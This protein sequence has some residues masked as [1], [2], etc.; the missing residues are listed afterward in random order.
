MDSAIFRVP[1]LRAVFFISLVALAIPPAFNIL[2]SYPSFNQVLVGFTEEDS[3]E[4]ANHFARTLPEGAIQPGDPYFQRRAFTQAVDAIVTD[5]DIRKLRIFSPSGEIVYSTVESE[6]GKINEKPY[7]HGIVAKGTPFSKVVVKGQKSAEGVTS[8][9]HVAEVYIPVMDEG[10]FLGALEFYHDL[11][12]RREALEA[13][14]RY[15]AIMSLAISVFLFFTIFFTL[16]RGAKAH[17]NQELQARKIDDLGRLRESILEAIGDGI[18]GVDHKGRSLFL[19][20]AGERL[21]GWKAEDFIGQDQHNLSHHTRSDGSSYPADECPIHLCM[22]DGGTRHIEGEVFWN[23]SGHSFPVDYTVAPLMETGGKRGAVVA[24]RD[25]S[26]RRIMEEELLLAKETAEKAN[27]TK[28]EFLANMS[29]EIRTP[30]N[31]VIGLSR[32]CLETGLDP[33][34]KDYV[35]KIHFS[36][37][38]LLGIINDILDFSKIEAGKLAVEHV[39]FDLVRILQNLTNLIAH[40]ADEKGVAFKI[41]CT[42]EVPGGFL[43]DPLRIEQVLRNLADNAVK[44]SDKGGEVSVS[45]SLEER[46]DER[47]TLLFKVRDRGIGLSEEAI[48][49]LFQSFSQADGS[50]TRKFGGTGLG[51]AICKQLVE[52]MGGRIWVES[53]EGE[54]S[55]FFFTTDL[56]IETYQEQVE[57]QVYAG[58]RGRRVLI[59]DPHEESRSVIDDMVRGFGFDVVRAIDA[60]SAVRLVEGGIEEG[61]PFD[62]VLIDWDVPGSTGASGWSM[63]RSRLTARQMP[64]VIL[65][66]DYEAKDVPF[67][68]EEDGIY[69]I[70]FRPVS[71]STMLDQIMTIF[72]EVPSEE[73]ATVGGSS[74]DTGSTIAPKTGAHLLLAEDNAINQ[75][76]A[77]ELLEKAGFVVSVAGDGQEAVE[78]VGAEEFDGVLM[79]IQMPVMDGYEATRQIRSESRFEGLPI[80]A[81]TANAMAGDREK[82]L[83][84]GMNDHITKPI[85]LDELHAA[86]SRW[87]KPK[88]G[89]GTDRR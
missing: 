51:L 18:F 62:L 8:E 89:G 19:N 36:A 55:T 42:R 3:H 26:D 84:A 64:T 5:F 82:C 74:G 53:R 68:D 4:A 63:M 83:E 48:A 60:F 28:S 13:Q 12:K 2:V 46:T 56:V 11:T 69:G 22:Q 23:R 24:F 71:A 30:M 16:Q 31:G 77:V 10:Q 29:H 73:A 54:G 81:M 61:K 87:I 9:T 35:E 14:L 17:L 80:I 41:S 44:F 67:P 79:D 70:L 47:A 85:N 86:L 39:P 34:Q 43:G 45:V 37:N 6:V 15:S 38:N 40:K 49:R 59:I 75:Q 21:L 58:L 32:L 78:K 20:P 66:A 27:Q 7:F 25:I 33:N 50:T 57:S 65:I 1:Y 76:I 72:G 88:S 52:L